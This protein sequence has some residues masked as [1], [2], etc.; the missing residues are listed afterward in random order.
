MGSDTGLR[1]RR[2]NA[3][4]PLGQ[5]FKE[6]SGLARWQRPG[7]DLQSALP[8][9]TGGLRDLLQQD[10]GQLPLTPG[11]PQAHRVLPMTKWHQQLRVWAPNALQR[12]TWVKRPTRCRSK[13]TPSKGRTKPGATRP[14]R[15]PHAR[16][17]MKPLAGTL[18]T[19]ET[20]QSGAVLN[21]L[22]A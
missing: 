9:G 5:R 11:R 1:P 20:L 12:R 17:A 16:T 2:L 13:T 7:T 19:P 18:A 8:R 14:H 10:A 6:E 22:D 21:S 3:R 4:L 15:P